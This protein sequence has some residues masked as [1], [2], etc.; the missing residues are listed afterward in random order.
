MSVATAITLIRVLQMLNKS[1]SAFPGSLAFLRKFFNS[2]NRIEAFLNSDEDESHIIKRTNEKSMTAAITIRN[3][4]FFWNFSSINDKTEKTDSENSQ[5]FADSDQTKTNDSDKNEKPNLQTF[6]ERITLKNIDL[7]INK[8]E[9]VAVVGDVGAGKSSLLSC[10]LG[11]MLYVDHSIIEEYGDLLLDDQNRDKHARAKLDELN[12][13]RKQASLAA[14]ARVTINGSVSL[15]EQRPFILSKTIRENILF[16]ELDNAH[17]FDRDKYNRVLNICQLGRDM[18]ILE[19][20][21]LTEIGERGINLSGGQK[22]R[23]S[24]ARA[25]Y[26]NSDIVLMDDPLSALDAHV[27][28][29]IFDEV[30]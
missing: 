26:A 16:E 3:A 19:G 5:N 27:K 10:L 24:I 15:V 21:D 20:G 25:V 4:N 18:E 1:I 29:R 17:E 30:C 7:V 23:I 14:G 11:E 2:V 6:K 12:R 22:A 8:G 9:F 28:K 13:R